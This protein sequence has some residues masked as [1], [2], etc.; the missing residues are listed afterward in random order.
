MKLGT[1]YAGNYLKQEDLQGKRVLLTI[2]RVEMEDLGQGD[3]KEAKPVC[4][5]R[6]REKGWVMPKT[7][8]YLIA[9]WYGDDTD[10]WAGKKIVL[11]VDPNVMYAGKRTGGIRVSP[12]PGFQPQAEEPI[13]EDDFEPGAEG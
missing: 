11:Y 4:Y 9:E 2:D 10:A 1:M 5:F 6:G 8:A 12:P 13:V 7:C 3:D